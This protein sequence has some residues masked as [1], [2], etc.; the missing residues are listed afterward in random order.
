MDGDYTPREVAELHQ[1]GQIALIDVRQNYVRVRDKDLDS[2]LDRGIEFKGDLHSPEREKLY[3]QA[4]K[5]IMENSYTVPL[6]YRRSFEAYRPQV[7]HGNIGYDPYGTYHYW[8]DVWLK[9]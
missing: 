8:N 1:A 3:K 6:Y 5:E 2:L 9:R 4:Q 7:Q